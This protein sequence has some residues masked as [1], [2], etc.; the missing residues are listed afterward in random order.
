MSQSGRF[1]SLGVYSAHSLYKVVNFKGVVSVFVPAMWKLI[2]PPR[3]QFL[4]FW[5]KGKI[6]TRNNLSKGQNVADSS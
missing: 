4:W 1:H 5:S 3:V 2:T 6:L